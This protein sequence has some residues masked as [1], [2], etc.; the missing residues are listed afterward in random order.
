M[1]RRSRSPKMTAKRRKSLPK[2]KFA[3]PGSRKYPLDTRGRAANAKAR[4][5]QMH[6]KGKISASTK[7]KIHAAA[8]RRLRR[9]Q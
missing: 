7:A 8:N 9:K 4:A 3:L 2:S 1:A 5:T 6:K